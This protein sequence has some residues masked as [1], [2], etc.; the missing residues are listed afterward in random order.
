MASYIQFK[1]PD[2]DA[3]RTLIG[4][5]KGDR[6]MANFADD[7]KR[8]CPGVR[9]SAPT[10]SRAMNWMEGS[11]P[12]TANLLEA[13]AK[14][15]AKADV[16]VTLEDLIAANGMRSPED[17]STLAQG[18]AY[19][20][21][22]GAADKIENNVRRIIQDEITRRSYS[23]QQLH[24]YSNWRNL[25]GYTIQEDRFFPRNY[26]FGFSV[27]GMSPC[28]IWKF[29][30]DPITV[31]KDD[32]TT[33][34]AHV[35]NFINKVGA[36]LASDNFEYELYENEK[37]SFVFIDSLMYKLFLQRV[38][39]NGI[40][41]NGFMTVILIDQDKGQVIEEMQLK[42]YDEATAVSFF[43]EPILK[44]VTGEKLMDPLYMVE[45]GGASNGRKN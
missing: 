3:L 33:A 25:Y 37:Y 21:N 32:E 7:I 19:A 23:L 18:D 30:V 9:V 31:D 17:D 26:T 2:A 10:L 12:V 1:S 45:E 14:V 43:K 41:V 29:A 27:S 35:G 38:S 44:T 40:C 39:Q 34:N 6:S 36:V 24:D 5:I 11:R 16:G 15:A 13:L 42:R 4:K 22:R 28:N 8:E 20:H